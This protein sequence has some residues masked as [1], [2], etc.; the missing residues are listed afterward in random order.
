MANQKGGR[1]ILSDDKIREFVAEG[2]TSGNYIS[3]V[4][5][6]RSIPENIIINS[7]IEKISKMDT[8]N[9]LYGLIYKLTLKDDVESPLVNMVV[10]EDTP[11]HGDLGKTSCSMNTFFR[12]QCLKSVR[13]FLIKVSFISTGKEVEIE[14]QKLSVNKADFILEADSQNYAYEKTFEYGESVVPACISPP[15]IDPIEQHRTIH[16]ILTKLLEPEID[17]DGWLKTLLKG[18]KKQDVKDFGIIFMEFAEGYRTLRDVLEDP[19]VSPLHHTKARI[20]AKMAHLSLYEKNIAQGDAHNQNIMI[21][22]NY[23]GFLGAGRKGKALVIDFGR[24]ANITE[25][26]KTRFGLSK[27]IKQEDYNN[28]FHYLKYVSNFRGKMSHPPYEWLVRNDFMGEED[29]IRTCFNQR[30]WRGQQIKAKFQAALPNVIKKDYLF[31]QFLGKDD[32]NNF[33]HLRWKDIISTYNY[34][35]PIKAV[36]PSFNKANSMSFSLT[37]S[38]PSRLPPIKYRELY[39]FSPESEA[40]DPKP[41][42][43]KLKV[44]ELP[45][46]GPRVPLTVKPQVIKIGDALPPIRL[47]GKKKK[48]GGKRKTK[49]CKK[50]SAK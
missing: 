38:P 16:P 15:I 19:L 50:M 41:I 29:L 6:Y 17:K 39:T 40:S 13:T 3:D 48:D 24:A 49:K 25:A 33:I 31:S 18:A 8:D 10:N 28:I 21:N 35:P 47:I 14:T 20:L 1:F 12:K 42:V 34:N 36:S 30:K 45:P 22:L 5:Y 2:L 37:P 43:P 46:L 32:F 23:V 27:N 11:D 26:D 4:R 44:R 9:S 7:T